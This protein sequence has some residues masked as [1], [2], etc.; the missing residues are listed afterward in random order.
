MDADAIVAELFGD[1]LSTSPEDTPEVA[2][3]EERRALDE[4]ATLAAESA[5]AVWRYKCRDERN[6]WR[7]AAEAWFEAHGDLSDTLPAKHHE[8]LLAHGEVEEDDQPATSGKPTK[9][10]RWVKGRWVKAKKPQPKLPYQYGTQPRGILEAT[11]PLSQLAQALIPHLTWRQ[12]GSKAKG[13]YQDISYAELGR[14]LNAHRQTVYEEVHRLQAD[15]WLTITSRGHAG[16]RFRLTTKC[17][18]PS[19]TESERKP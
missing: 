11:P 13:F 17:F 12:H 2:D 10:G 4:A 15:G 8:R 18:A 19:V 5:A 3:A 6:A 9:G 7:Q 1:D 14:L 16:C